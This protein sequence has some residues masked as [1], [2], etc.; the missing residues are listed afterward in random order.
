MN[1]KQLLTI[2]TLTLLLTSC[3]QPVASPT[4]TAEPERP[5]PTTALARELKV[6]ADDVTLHVR[7]AGNP[8]AGDVLIAI[9]GGPGNSSDYMISLEQLASAEFAVVNYDQ[10]GAGQ[11]TEPS[12]D[13]TM[14]N[15]IADLEAVR[16]AVGAEAVHLLGHS[17]GGLV[18]LRY[19]VAHPQRVHSIILMGS[20][21]L[22]PQAAQAGQANKAERIAALQQQ[23]IIPQP[24]TSLTDILPAYFSDPSFDMPD[25]LKSMHYN[26]DVEQMTWSALGDYDF[27]AGVDTLN[28]PVLVL[29]GEDDPFG[30]VYVEA[31]KSA[32]S[33]ATVEIAVLEK[34][35]HYWHECPDEF[36]SHV[37]AFLKF[38]PAP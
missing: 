13:Y 38:P 32:L 31:T 10:R 34:C 1:R 25:E 15:Y 33:A 26:P 35:G 2:L 12:K 18:A 27:A 11:S 19:A 30:M 23:G 28:H 6:Q 3:G 14:D 7:V 24:I 20:G 21:V 17:W 36:F 5:M 29:W 9:H 8:K 16:Q 4:P 37:R 22:T